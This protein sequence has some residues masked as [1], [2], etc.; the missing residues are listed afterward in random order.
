MGGSA[1]TLGFPGI[2][3][4]LLLALRR[5]TVLPSVLMSMIRADLA[6]PAGPADI[7]RAILLC[8]VSLASAVE[9]CTRVPAW[10]DPPKFVSVTRSIAV[11]ITSKE[12]VFFVS[13]INPAFR[14]PFRA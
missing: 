9:F 4:K 8:E 14:R 10:T 5:T 2:Q 6:M 3:V 7:A 11:A 13:F 1:I 12:N